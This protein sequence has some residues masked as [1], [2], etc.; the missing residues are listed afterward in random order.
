MEFLMNLSDGKQFTIQLL[1]VLICLFYGARK[2]GIALGLL[3]GIGMFVLTFGFGVS[4]GK[5]AIDVIFT[6][7]CV[8][9]ASATL[10]ASG[11]LDPNLFPKVTCW[12]WGRGIGGC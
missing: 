10:L 9:V 6:I 7:L 1:I 2:G 8:V 4:P 3:G 12:I 5:P 11:G